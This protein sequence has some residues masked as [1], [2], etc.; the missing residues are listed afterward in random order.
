[1]RLGIFFIS[2]CSYT[3]GINSLGCFLHILGSITF[4]KVNI[5]ISSFFYPLVF[6]AVYLFNQTIYSFKHLLNMSNL[7]R[8][9]EDAARKIS[10]YTGKPYVFIIALLLIIVWAVSGPIFNYSDTWQLVI[11]TS[12]TIITFLMVFLVQSAQNR[13]SKALQLKLDELILK[14]DQADNVMIDIEELGEDELAELAA[15]YKEIRASHDP[16]AM[17]TFKEETKRVKLAKKKTKD[18]K[19]DKTKSSKLNPI[20]SKPA[21]VR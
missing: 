15:K 17:Q 19:E 11:N 20:K 13:D 4:I 2:T 18:K 5:Y 1:M 16:E 14:I 6:K 8:F 10:D 9:F 3:T 7:K 12:T 21:L